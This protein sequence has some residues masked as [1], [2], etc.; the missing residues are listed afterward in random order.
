MPAATHPTVTVDLPITR[1]G[2]RLDVVVDVDMTDRTPADTGIE[3]ETDRAYAL[4][5]GE[6]VHALDL[7]D[8]VVAARTG[9]WCDL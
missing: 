9:T 6:R 7:A 3:G 1:D 4:T 5:D 8:A 2:V